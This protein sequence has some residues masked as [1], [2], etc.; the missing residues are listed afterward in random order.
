[1]EA[2]ENNGYKVGYT[3]KGWGPGDP[4]KVDGKSRKLT[5]PAFNDIKMDARTNAISPNNYTANFKAF[6]EQGPQDK[7]FLFWYGGH[8]PHRAYEYG[9]GVAKGNN[10]LSDIDTVPPYW[11]DNE[12]VRNDMLDYAYEVEYFDHHLGQMLEVLEKEANS[13]IQS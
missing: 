8:E 5:G 4:G 12:Q 13:K 7:P 11:I 10:K 6:L 9:S 3:G 2:L 1:M